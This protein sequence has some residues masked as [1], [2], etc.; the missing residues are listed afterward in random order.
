MFEIT[1]NAISV[2]F[3]HGKKTYIYSNS[4]TG[5]THVDAM[6]S[7]AISGRGLSTYIAEN[8]SALLFT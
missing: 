4:V 6:K 3:N 5:K 2:N 7:L 8:K 1:D